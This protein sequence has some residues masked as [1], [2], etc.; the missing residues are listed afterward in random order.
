MSSTT[1]DETPQDAVTELR[2]ISRELQGES[3]SIQTQG[4]ALSQKEQER[5][6]AL[7]KAGSFIDQAIEVLE[8]V[9]S[10]S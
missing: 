1:R 5:V 4:R 7:N 3:G 9:G 2:R 8:G 10:Q 6:E